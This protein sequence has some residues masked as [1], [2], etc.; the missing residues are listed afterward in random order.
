MLISL[1]AIPGH[2]LNALKRSRTR[3][4]SESRRGGMGG[5]ASKTNLDQAGVYLLLRM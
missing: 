5:W 2:V 1:M 4:A 3:H